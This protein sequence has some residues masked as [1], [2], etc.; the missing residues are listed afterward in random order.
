MPKRGMGRRR[1]LKLSGAGIVAAGAVDLAGCA[2]AKP[3]AEGATSG[4][5]YFDR[6]G[7]TEPMLA[8]VLG[9]AMSRG[10][11]SADVYFQHKVSAGLGLQDGA[12][13]RSS[14]QVALGVGVRA[15]KGDQQGYGFT[16][17]L[18]LPAI[19]ECARTAAAIADGPARP[20]PQRFRV[21]GSLPDRYPVKVRWRTSAPSRPCPS[22]PTWRPACWRATPG[23]GR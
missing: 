10:A 19:L 1:F 14:A 16:E 22:S 8:Q 2:T 6:F 11:D 9:E 13:N 15:V 5:R 18:S 17:D 7:V 23:C 3:K 12:V 21:A 4:I 20:G